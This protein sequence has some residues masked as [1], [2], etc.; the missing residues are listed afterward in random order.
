[1]CKIYIFSH[2]KPQ[3]AGNTWREQRMILDMQ[4]QEKVRSII[5]EYEI[6]TSHRKEDKRTGVLEVMS[7]GNRL[8]VK[9]YGRTIHWH[10]ELYAYKNWIPAIEPFAPKLISAFEAESQF[11]II[12][13]SIDGRTVNELQ[14]QDDDKLLAIY[15]EAGKL[16]KKMQNEKYGE[17]F[18][19]IKDDGNSIDEHANKNPVTYVSDFIEFFYKSLHNKKQI[20]DSYKPLIEWAT[21]ECDI[22]SD[23]IPVPT[24]WDLSPQNWLVNDSGNFTGFID[25]EHT[26]WGISL[27]SFGVVTHR[28]AYDKPQLIKSF[29]E[30]YGLVLDEVTKHKMKIL[31]IKQALAELFSGYAGNHQRWIDC[32][33]K[34][35]EV[36]YRQYLSL[37]N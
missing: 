28:Y 33:S 17:F 18:G 4:T 26:S 12:I 2:S 35:L 24:N 15:Y 36:A 11:G 5:G 1:V 9:V 25:F 10:R 13:T 23:E 27:D 8:F 6:I 19:F 21:R 31:D 16:F 14:I 37:L 20:D 34:S 29:F 30:G 22:F 7:R 32:G 3:V